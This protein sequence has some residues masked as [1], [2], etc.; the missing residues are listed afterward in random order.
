MNTRNDSRK[1]EGLIKGI[2]AMAGALLIG[3][4][5]L[6]LVGQTGVGQG[7]AGWSVDQEG[8]GTLPSTSSG[9][10]DAGFGK[11]V[12][13]DR[14]SFYLQGTSVE[15]LSSAIVSADGEQLWERSYDRDGQ[16]NGVRVIF[17]GDV[18]LSVDASLFQQPGVS[19]GLVVGWTMGDSYAAIVYQD[20]FVQ[21]TTMPANSVFPVPFAAMQNAGILGDGLY[22][23]SA[24]V[25]GGRNLISVGTFPGLVEI[26]QR[27]MQG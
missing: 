9:P 26:D 17:H 21:Q 3:L 27:E 16:E 7:L 10:G 2:G 19:A 15:Q 22:F 5:L 18:H 13:E 14:P 24:N 23:F 25:H 6:S 4:A 11:T 12:L 1:G 8:T 20:R